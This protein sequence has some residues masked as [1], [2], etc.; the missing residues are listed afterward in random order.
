MQVAV[1]TYPD[2]LV[3]KILEKQIVIFLCVNERLIQI[4]YMQS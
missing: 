1:Q 3:R 2:K 4:L